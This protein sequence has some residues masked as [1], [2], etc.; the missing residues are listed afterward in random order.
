M[1]HSVTSESE[2]ELAKSSDEESSPRERGQLW[3]AQQR[4][5]FIREFEAEMRAQE[6]LW[7]RRRVL[8]AR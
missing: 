2:S 1:K 5:G 7:A 8:W 6:A 4:A 3:T